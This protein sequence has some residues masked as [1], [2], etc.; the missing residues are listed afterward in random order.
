M[1]PIIDTTKKTKPNIIVCTQCGKNSTEVKFSAR[2]TV[3]NECR[4]INNRKNR[5]E[6]II[7]TLMTRYDLTDVEA[8][9]L[10]KNL[11]KRRLSDKFVIHLC[12]LI[13]YLRNRDDI[14]AMLMPTDYGTISVVGQNKIYQLI[15]GQ[16]YLSMYEAKGFLLSQFM[17]GGV[18]TELIIVPYGAE[19]PDKA[20]KHIELNRAGVLEL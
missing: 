6:Q 8:S 11:G 7:N 13:K 5:R 12:K 4:T 1:K 14:Y 2:F 3:C 20:Y 17:N 19:L 18:S 10:S 16:S 9:M 15:S